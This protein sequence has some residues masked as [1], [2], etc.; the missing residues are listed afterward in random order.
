MNR[1]VDFYDRN[2]TNPCPMLA[3]CV[4]LALT[5]T[6]C[7]VESGFSDVDAGNPYAQAIQWASENGYVNGYAK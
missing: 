2:E 5:A 4:M 1:K 3:L 6:A 7:A